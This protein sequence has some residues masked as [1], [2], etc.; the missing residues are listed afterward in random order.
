MG[1]AAFLG[2]KRRY[3]YMGR[4]AGGA[5]VIHDYAHHPSE[6]DAVMKVA[7]EEAERL[8]VVFEPHTYSRTQALFPDFVQVLSKADVLIMLPTYSAR[9][10]PAEGV[11]AET[12][13]CGI[14]VPERYYFSDYDGAKCL[15]DRISTSRD[16]VL[17][18]GAGS[19]EKLAERFSV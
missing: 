13:F 12:L 16:V 19:V 6:I 17:I 2:V 7:R 5:T 15:L 3:E 10:F 14:E 1:L 8:I 18:L 9:E 11:D 4:T